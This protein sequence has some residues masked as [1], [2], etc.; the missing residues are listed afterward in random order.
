MSRPQEPV[1]SV[2]A[3]CAAIDDAFTRSWP[4]LTIS[5]EISNWVQS[6]SGHAYFSLKDASA[7]LRCVAFRRVLGQLDFQPAS[8]QQ[9]QITARLSLYQPR[10]DMQLV[11]EAITRPSAGALYEAFL[12]LKA[13]LQAEGL[14]EQTRKRPLPSFAQRIGLVTSAAGAAQHDVA[15]TL[16]RR[17]PHVQVQF[18]PASVQGAA[19]PAELVAALQALYR[20]PAAQRPEV[21]LLVRGGGSAEDLAAFNNEALARCIAA[22]PVPI[23][24]GVGHESDFSIADMVAD[25]RA[26]T[27]TAAAELAAPERAQLLAELDAQAA[28]LHRQ[29][30]QRLERA[31]QWL[32]QA[33]M[34]LAHQRRHTVQGQQARLAQIQARIRSAALHKL[35]NAHYQLQTQ[36]QKMRHAT[37]QQALQMQY[38]LHTQSLQCS[39]LLRQQLHQRSQA[40]SRCEQRLLALQAARAAQTVL[41]KNASGHTVCSVDDVQTGEQLQAV[42]ADGLLQVQVLKV[43]KSTIKK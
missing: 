29:M 10:G 19:A 37:G 3:L 39:A 9:V 11:V 14:F 12:R 33:E 1:W 34:Q 41:L 21:I 8:G 6:A 18:A 35:Q 27:P 15:Q 17:A 43:E 13:K 30:Q 42:L 7:Q 40:L 22:S 31:A 28:W 38:L 20:L 25:M 2:S 36:E 24:S 4:A 32:D 26:A 23:I 16:A 5:G